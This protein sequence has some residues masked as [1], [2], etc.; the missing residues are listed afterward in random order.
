MWLIMSENNESLKQRFPSVANACLI[1]AQEYMMRILRQSDGLA[2]QIPEYPIYEGNSTQFIQMG[3]LDIG[4][5]SD[6]S[7]EAEFQGVSELKAASGGGAIRNEDIRYTR[8]EE[9]KG[10]LYDIAFALSDIRGKMI[11]SEMDTILDKA[12]RTTD[13]G[14]QNFSFELWL[15]TLEKLEI[16]FDEDGK[17]VM[18]AA[19][20]PPAMLPTVNRV[21]AEADQDAEKKQ[22]L[23]DLIE[24]KRE[25]FNAKEANRKLVD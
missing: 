8:L 24:R 2:S 6:L 22:L 10:M 15:N 13:A 9:F 18:P 21:F 19:V 25:E 11:F 16:E 23:R 7:V 3:R 1:A 14:G 4:E 5:K 17:P 12:G 20:I